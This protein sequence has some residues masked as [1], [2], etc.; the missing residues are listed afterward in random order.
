MEWRQAPGGGE[1]SDNKTP[2]KS[3]FLFGKNTNEQGVVV[4]NIPEG[5]WMPGHGQRIFPDKLSPNDAI[6]RNTV[7]LR[8]TV[9]PALAGQTVY[10]RAFDVDDPV[11]RNF[12]KKGQLDENDWKWNG[13]VER[14]YDARSEIP[15]W[16][17]NA[18]AGDYRGAVGNDNRDDTLDTPKAGRFLAGSNITLSEAG[19]IA[20][21][22]V[23]AQGYV[24]FIFQ[25]GMQPGNNY[26]VA[27]TLDPNE[28]GFDTLQVDGSQVD[29]STGYYGYVTWVSD[30]RTI[31][32]FGGV[33]SPML[34]V[35]RKLYLEFDSMEAG[36]PTTGPQ[37]NVVT[38]TVGNAH[39]ESNGE[40]TLTL[41]V[42]GSNNYLQDENRFENGKIAIAD[43]GE[44]SVKRNWS[45]FNDMNGKVMV[46]G[47]SGASVSG[48]YFSLI[49]DDDFYLTNAG[50]SPLLP[51]DQHSDEI[52][53]AIQ[54]VY[55]DSYIL[56]V[57]ANTAGLNPSPSRQIPFLLN[58]SVGGLGD[59]LAE[60]MVANDSPGFW[61]HRIVFGYQ[62]SRALDSD[63][64]DGPV[65]NLGE[66]P[67][68]WILLMRSR[69]YSAIF[70]ETI[71]D[72][73]MPLLSS[74]ELSTPYIMQNR[75]K[76]FYNKLYAA[77]AHEIGHSPN[78]QT[79]AT[80]HA[81]GSLMAGEVGSLATDYFSAATVRRFRSSN[82]WR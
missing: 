75:N 6:E 77:I 10:V 56:L 58:Q 12:D 31:A 7:K 49:D 79:D 74:S 45:V 60:N 54:S 62:S 35:W 80:D 47:F 16:V 4:E 8:V 78:R 68:N 37:G 52:T 72:V 46:T 2:T 14:V 33:L 82:S 30:Q 34:T 61:F 17:D 51:Y 67:K 40:T 69:G 3:R 71:R 22:I 29:G 57:D 38:G 70:L 19:D 50:I 26:R 25:V 41:H 63:P 42:N 48:K 27:M 9:G 64:N 39:T 76:L 44:F 36:P 32:G 66:T 21:G 11:D 65:P 5:T 20:S 53:K 15:G 28:A 24:D 1:V 81:E 13:P 59:P 55:T 23:G 43:A 18:T 73:V